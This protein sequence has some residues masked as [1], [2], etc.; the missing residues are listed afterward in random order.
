M[1]EVP[2]SW[3]GVSS[4]NSQDE[5]DC[6]HSFNPFSANGAIGNREHDITRARWRGRRARGSFSEGVIARF[7]CVGAVRFMKAPMSSP[8]DSQQMLAA[9]NWRY[10]TKKFDTTKKIPAD[11]WKA[12]EQS[13][14]LTPSSFNLQPWKFV[15][16]ENPELR[17]QLMEASWKQAQPVEAS[18]FVVFALRKNTDAAYVDRFI[19]RSAQVLG[20][21][22]ESL[23]SLKNS[24]LKGVEFVR[25][26][27]EL[28]Y[29]QSRQVYIALGQF[30]AA[31]AVL[32]VDT[33]P[34]EGLNPAKYDEILGLAGTEYTTLCACAAGYRAADDKYATTPKVRFETGDVVQYV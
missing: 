6:G 20:R 19:V 3:Q 2:S 17:R 25:K 22:I 1:Q 30:I 26:K 33:S 8:F 13:L 15:V 12:L 24:I 5:L 23:E 21:S 7:A 18:H 34:M 14:V 10:S 31:A 32:G 27:G 28:D 16:V 29:W 9:L 11:V 4:G